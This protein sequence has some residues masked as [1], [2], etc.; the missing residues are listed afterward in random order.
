MDARLKGAK[1]GLVIVLIAS[2]LG[3]GLYSYAGQKD[4][5]AKQGKLLKSWSNQRML[6]ELGTPASVLDCTQL[7]L[8]GLSGY[9]WVD[10]MHE[11]VIILC[12]SPN[13]F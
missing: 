11:R 7:G 9:V 4:K 5:E 10:Q 3:V 12:V 8:Q 13:G 2:V 6:D 1:I